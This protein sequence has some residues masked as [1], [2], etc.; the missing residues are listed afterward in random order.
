MLGLHMAMQIW[1]AQTS[2]IAV[3]VGT[4]VPQQQNGILKDLIVLIFDSQIAVGPGKVFLFKFLET[5]DGIVG[6][7]H[8]V[9]FGLF[10]KGKYGFMCLV[11]TD[12]DHS[13]PAMSASF[14]LI[15]CAKP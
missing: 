2:H 9:G 13:Y 11:E 3:F 6:E 7:N 1:P 10:A 14:I 15:Q 4:I 8:K 5:S 12:R